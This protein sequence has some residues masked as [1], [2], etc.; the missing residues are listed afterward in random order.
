VTAADSARLAVVVPTYRRPDLLRRCLTSLREQTVSASSFEIAV[1]DDASADATPDVLRAAAE[2]MPNLVWASQPRNRGPAA[3]RNRAV[4]MTSAP[5]V[6]FIDDDVVA[7]P[8][9]VAT[10]LRLHEGA[11]ST[12]GVV[13][14]VEWLPELT[15][16]PFMHWLDGTNLQFAFHTW[17]EPGPLG[18]PSDAFYTCNLSLHREIFEAAG[19]FDE[20][21]PY[22]AYEDIELGIRLAKLGFVLTYDPQALGWHARAITL[23]E[24]TSRMSK[25]AESAVLLR[26]SHPELNVDVDGPVSARRPAVVRAALRLVQGVLPRVGGKDVRSAYY[27]SEVG[28]AWQRGLHRAERAE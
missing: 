25:V 23:P 28:A 7:A 19:A 2:Q 13:G 4:A 12:H 15:V 14:L 20:R 6:L 16:T 5:L 17:L 9:L 27:W 22:P 18:H 11:P 10:H 3:A 26:S 8:D 21:F 24:F 1:V